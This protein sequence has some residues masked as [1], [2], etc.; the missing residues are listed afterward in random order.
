LRNDEGFYRDCALRSH[1]AAPR[2]SRERQ[3]RDVLGIAK[4]VVEG[5][6]EI[7]GGKEMTK[8]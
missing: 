5:K 3:A 7:V 6:G 1:G 4:L 2:Y 8:T